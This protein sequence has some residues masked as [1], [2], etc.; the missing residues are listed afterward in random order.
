MILW[1][2]AH[3][4]PLF[5]GFSRKEYW[6]G[7][8]CPA[9]R[10]LLDPRMEPECLMSPSL[11]G[12]FFT[13]SATWKVKSLSHVQLVV[14]PWTVACQA[15]LSMEFSRQEYW[16]GLPCPLPRDLPDPGVEPTSLMS[17]AS[18][19]GFFTTAAAAKS[20]QSCLTRCD[21]MDCSLPGS[22]VH[23]ILQARILEWVNISFSRGSSLPRNRTWVSCITGG[24]FTN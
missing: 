24:F 6:S 1:T 4:A 20:L 3:Q 13:T 21:P 5:R 23:G 19:G 16:S 22:F 10:Y 7:L 9:P 18:A 8:P 2:V 12:K 15:P 17:S 14:T 11:A